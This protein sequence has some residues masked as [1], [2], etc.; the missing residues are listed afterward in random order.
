MTSHAK[1]EPENENEAIDETKRNPFICPICLSLMKKPITLICGHTFCRHC[2][3]YSVNLRIKNTADDPRNCLCPVCRASLRVLAFNFNVN[4]ILW[5]IIK[6]Q[7][8]DEATKDTKQ[9]DELYENEKKALLKHENDRNGVLDVTDGPFGDS[10][11]YILTD[12]LE[13]TYGCLSRIIRNDLDEENHPTHQWTLAFAQFPNQILKNNALNFQVAIIVM[14][15]DEVSDGGFPKI[16]RSAG[17]RNLRDHTYTGRFHATIV[18]NETVVVQHLDF[19]INNGISSMVN[20]DS[21]LPSG[22]YTLF[23]SECTI[24][25]E[26]MEEIRENNLQEAINLDAR[27]NDEFVTRIGLKFNFR[28]GQNDDTMPENSIYFGGRLISDDEISSGVGYII[29]AAGSD[30]E[31]EEEEDDDMDGF[32]VDDDVVEYASDYEEEDDDNDESSSSDDNES[33]TSNTRSRKRSSDGNNNTNDSHDGGANKRRRKNG[34][35]IVIEDSDDD[36][37]D[38]Y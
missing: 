37:D 35:V 7:F 23:I 25:V 38:D 15:E 2:L 33:D 22:T 4:I 14:E 13:T 32:V 3:L 5:N 12:G 24:P 8:S 27:L 17:D 26:D 29:G 21:M 16:L 28:I 11:R 31:E 10:G 6:N 34:R 20:F 18:M 19:D 30:E 36:D 9:I 1:G